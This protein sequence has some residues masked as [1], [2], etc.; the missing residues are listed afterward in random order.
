VP[1]RRQ[2]VHPAASC[3]LC[4]LACGV[5]YQTALVLF[6]IHLRFRRSIASSCHSGT[7]SSLNSSHTRHAPLRAPLMLAAAALA[8]RSPSPP[9]PQAPPPRNPPHQARPKGLQKPSSGPRVELFKLGWQ[10]GARPSSGNVLLTNASC[11]ELDPVCA[12]RH[13]ASRD[14]TRGQAI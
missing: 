2:T 13:E 12:P 9:P 4:L 6:D 11:V 7:C 1:L 5:W 3:C 10:N 8:L 14:A